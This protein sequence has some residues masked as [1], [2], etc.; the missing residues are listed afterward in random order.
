MLAFFTLPLNQLRYQVADDGT[1]WIG[2]CKGEFKDLTRD[3]FPLRG[4]V[5]FLNAFSVELNIHLHV[6][7]KL[8]HIFMCAGLDERVHAYR[9]EGYPCDNDFF[10]LRYYPEADA[11]L[12]GAQVALS[13]PKFRRVQQFLISNFGRA[14]VNLQL[15]CPF[16]GFKEPYYDTALPTHTEFMERQ[17]YFVTG[18]QRL[19]FGISTDE[20]ATHGVDPPERDHPVAP[21]R[22]WWPWRRTG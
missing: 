11:P 2:Q 10:L 13:R 5:T 20:A 8:N 4:D 14:D 19:A 6:D 7:G 18:E 22:S 3:Y 16:H 12:L 17:P 1:W 15:T 9:K 21:Q